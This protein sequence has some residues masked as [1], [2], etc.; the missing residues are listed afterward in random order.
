M[1]TSAKRSAEHA[2]EHYAAVAAR[3]TAV[4]ETVEKPSHAVI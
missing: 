3:F 4:V 2:V 1:N